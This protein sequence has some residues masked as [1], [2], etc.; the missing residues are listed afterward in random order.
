MSLR[1]K[2]AEGFTDPSG[3]LAM[4]P[5]GAACLDES[6]FTKGNCQ[7]HYKVIPSEKQ[8][9]TGNIDIPRIR[10]LFKTLQRE[11]LSLDTADASLC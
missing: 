9:P 6:L 5:R 4:S 1:G 10:N 8:D 3:D 11:R 2:N 7:Y